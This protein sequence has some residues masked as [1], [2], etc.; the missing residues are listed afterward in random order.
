MGKHGLRATDLT[1]EIGK[2]DWKT[3]D[4]TN[5]KLYK[6]T[7]ILNQSQFGR[8]K[9]S[10]KTPLVLY[11]TQLEFGLNKDFNNFEKSRN[12]RKEVMYLR[13]LLL[14]QGEIIYEIEQFK[15][16]GNK[17][18]QAYYLL[19]ASW[20]HSWINVKLPLWHFYTL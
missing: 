16:L 4:P 3:T 14:I 11:K 10:I 6:S 5:Q 12:F 7:S 19:D 1:T 2:Y 8:S 15:K 13:R 9:N 18:Q 17:Y 20:M